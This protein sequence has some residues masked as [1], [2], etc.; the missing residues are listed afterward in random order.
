MSRSQVLAG[1]F[2]AA[3]VARLAA[4]AVLGGEQF[5]FVDE[6]L[7]TA[8]ATGL[9]QGQDLS[10]AA[11]G[12]PGYPAFL[13]VL[14]LALPSGVLALRL[15]QAVVAA[16]GVPLAWLLGRRLGGDTAGLAAAII[17]ALDPLLVASAG[18]LYP[19]TPAALLVSASVLVA[20]RAVRGD[21]LRF[22]ALGGVLLG[23]VTLFRPVS[24]ALGAAMLGWTVLGQ[25]AP[26]RRR[27][28]HGALLLGTWA[29][30]LAPWLAGNVRATGHLLPTGVA[31]RQSVGSETEEV[32]LGQGLA[33]AATRDPGGL[34]SRTL[35]EFIHFWEL[36]PSR[37]ATDDPARRA[38]LAERFPELSDQPVA[39]TG[40]RDVVSALSFGAEV[41][42]ALLGLVVS[43]RRRPRETVWLVSLV[44]CFALGYALFFGKIRYRIPILPLIFAFA[45]L[46]AAEA[47][48]L[49]R[50]RRLD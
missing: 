18:L 14:Q 5:R 28:A 43:W 4:A 22:S 3:L 38:R 12:S 34:A 42:L 30:V 49:L 39:R 45:G 1:V 21:S 26:W 48:K 33:N 24:L 35:R 47:L 50:P 29:V 23:V 44:M 17:F 41:L 6:S 11:R 13:A 27:A 10:V 31:V 40:L 9:L 25:E 20:W 19:E 2:A 7:Y 32:G 46:G 16:L 36:T 8:A 37:L 15:A